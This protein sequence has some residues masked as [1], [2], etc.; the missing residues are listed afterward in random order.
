MAKQFGFVRDLDDAPEIHHGHAVADMG[1]DGEVM[2]DEQVREIV[3]AL[4]VD[5]Q[6]DHLRLDRDV[7]RG[8][9]LVAHDQTRPERQR[10]RDAD[11]LPLP[12]GELMRIILHLVRPQAD[13]REQFGDAGPVARGRLQ[14]RA[15]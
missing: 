6:V 14:V 1:D 15:R 12:A 10:P 5:Q 4:Q 9:R 7:E 2:G 8:D 11:A 3:L 13:L